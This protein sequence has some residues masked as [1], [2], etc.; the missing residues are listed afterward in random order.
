MKYDGVDAYKQ[1]QVTGAS[2]GQLVLMLYDHVLKCLKESDQRGACKGIVELMGA[3][4]VDYQEISGR[5]FSLYEF[6]LEQVKKG[7]TEE[8]CKMLTEMRDMWATAIN[9]MTAES[10]S[11]KPEGDTAKETTDV[12]V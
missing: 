7:N 8:A 3:L 5:L 9:K 11:D 4:D 10:M 12:I 2:P 6:C 1:S